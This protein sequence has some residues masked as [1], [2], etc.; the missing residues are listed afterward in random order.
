[1]IGRPEPRTRTDHEK[2]PVRRCRDG[3]F[4][5]AARGVGERAQGRAYL[6]LSLSL[7][8]V[9]L[10]DIASP[11]CG[12]VLEVLDDVLPGVM[13]PDV[14]PV[15]LVVA[16]DDVPDVPAPVVPDVPMPDVP[17]PDVP[18]ALEPVEDDVPVPVDEVVLDGLVVDGLIVPVLLD[19][20]DVLL[21]GEVVLDDELV[22]GLV[23]GVELLSRWQPATPIAAA[24][25]NTAQGF[26][27]MWFPPDG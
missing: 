5:R 3:P 10:F 14:L 21:V 18:D 19:D 17:A 11:G 15:P 12:V 26:G 16:P 24:T 8:A 13:L 27:F 6:P 9:P 23:E 25:A 4:R 2:R 7:L 1:M 22:D 20:G